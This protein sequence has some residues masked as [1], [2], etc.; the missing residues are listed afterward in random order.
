M[1]DLISSFVNTGVYTST[2]PFVW[3]GQVPGTYIDESSS[4]VLPR[5]LNLINKVKGD[6]TAAD[7]LSVKLSQVTDHDATPST[8]NQELSCWMG[9][10]G[11]FRFHTATT[12]DLL[13]RQLMG[14]LQAQMDGKSVIN[15]LMLGQR[16]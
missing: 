2:T 10:R 11:D 13:L 5:R 7:S 15:R 6:G 1:P 3:A 16:F 12:A 14:V 4:L 9:V 8:P